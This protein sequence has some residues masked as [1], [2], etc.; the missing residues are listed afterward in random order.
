VGQHLWI[1]LGPFFD[2]DILISFLSKWLLAVSAKYDF[3]HGKTS[4]E[5]FGV[6]TPGKEPAR[7]PDSGLFEITLFRQFGAFPG[8]DLSSGVGKHLKVQL[9]RAIAP[10]D[11]NAMAP[12]YTH[13]VRSKIVASRS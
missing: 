13:P 10:R 1:S 9:T 3:G 5:L 8:R 6:P 2:K 12:G 7:M 11:G 4:W